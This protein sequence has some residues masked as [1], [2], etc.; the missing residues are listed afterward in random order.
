MN[1]LEGV[2]NCYQLQKIISVIK[3]TLALSIKPPKFCNY[4]SIVHMYKHIVV[5][6]I[7]L[8]YFVL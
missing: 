3:K 1:K 8:S 5:L 4:E 7:K 2:R 6:L